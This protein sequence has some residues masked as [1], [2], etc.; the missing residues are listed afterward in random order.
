ML[1]TGLWSMPWTSVLVQSFSLFLVVDFLAI[2]YHPLHFLVFIYLSS[3]YLFWA[4]RLFRHS[5]RAHCLV[6]L[7]LFVFVIW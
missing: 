5:K 6:L 1:S 3:V 7:D 4:F 2:I